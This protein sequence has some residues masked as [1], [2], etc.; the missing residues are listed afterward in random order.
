VL[1]MISL[2]IFA[3]VVIGLPETKGPDPSVSMKARNIW[4]EYSIVFKH[5]SFIKYSLCGGI[6]YAGMFAYIAGSPFVFME[7]FEL[8]STQYAW[9]FA[10][11]ASGLILGSQLNR[12][13]LSKF[14][15]ENVLRCSSLGLVTVGCVLLTTMVMG[16]AGTVST[17][18]LTFLF[19]LCLGFLNPNAQALALRPLTKTA[20]RGSAIL[21]SIQM[22]AAALASWAVSFLANG[23]MIIM[24]M[25][26]LTCAI[27]TLGLAFARVMTSD[28]VIYDTEK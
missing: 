4:Q 13:A 28:R 6:G 26:M 23:T 7:A 25:V 1:A 27:L 22:T 12:I 15:I 24:P 8:S 2:I 3:A 21:G 19:L 5:P 10:F 16:F 11:N 18:I 17:L 20:G 14:Q 9:A